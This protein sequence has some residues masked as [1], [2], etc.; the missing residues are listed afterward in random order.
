MNGKAKAIPAFE[1]E[2]DERALWE[3]TDS[4]DHV[5]W[6]KAEL[7]RLPNLKPSTASISYGCQL[8]CSSE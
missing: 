5:D 1:T 4:S 2:N 7:V 6:R 8:L 3:A